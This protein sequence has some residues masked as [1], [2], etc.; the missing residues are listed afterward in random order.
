MFHYCTEPFRVPIAGKLNTNSVLLATPKRTRTDGIVRTDGQTKFF[1]TD[2]KLLD[3]R[4]KIGRKKF[5]RKKI[6]K[7]FRTE[8]NLDEKN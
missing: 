5:G 6:S 3:G 1:R 2:G 8:K 4:K 7:K